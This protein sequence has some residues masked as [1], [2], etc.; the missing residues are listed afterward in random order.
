MAK[1]E[2]VACEYLRHH[3]PE[4]FA[5]PYERKVGDR[6]AALKKLATSLGPR[7]ASCTLNG[8]ECYHPRQTEVRAQLV[9]FAYR[10]PTVLEAGGGLVLFGDPGTGKDHL[11]AALLKVAVGQH[12]LDVAW[13]DAGDLLDRIYFAIRSD[14][15]AAL[16]EL[17][18]GLHR[19]HVLAISDPQPPHGSLSDSQLRRLRDVIDRRYRAGLSTWL[20]TNLD[21]REDAEKLLT[22]PVIQR[23]K[24]ASLVILCD[25][26]SYR[27]RRKMA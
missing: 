7:Y 9:D 12:A 25:W 27:E 4:L 6:G 11:V 16:R 1:A 8:Y 5:S 26:P 2:S 3:A 14:S 23:L 10:M 22:A 18:V 20:T 19:P 15:E 17:M 13:Y 24:E 21:R